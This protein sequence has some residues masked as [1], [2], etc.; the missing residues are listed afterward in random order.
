[1]CFTEINRIVRIKLRNNISVSARFILQIIKIS[2]LVGFLII[3]VEY[4]NSQSNISIKLNTL[5]YQITE[6][7][8]NIINRTLSDN[9]KLALEPGVVFSYDAYASPTA[10][11]HISQAFIFDKASHLAGATG[12]M[13]KFRIIKYYQHSFYVAFGT[14]LHYR[15]TWENID[16][17]L[18]ESAYKESSD[19]QY[20]F[21]WLSGEIEYNYY[22]N[23][24]NDLSFSVLHIQAETVGFAIGI[25]HW[26]SKHQRKKRGCVSCPGLH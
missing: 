20:K 15:Q 23:K 13:V 24:M 26:I 25:K 21:N 19:W 5:T 7:Q 17:Y 3:K 22:I 2:L 9:G 12:L 8:T 18:P 11:L 6:P 1:M 16:G 14:S 10:A 4:A